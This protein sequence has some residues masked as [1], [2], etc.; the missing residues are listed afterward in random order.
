MNLV[1]HVEGRDTSRHHWCGRP[2]SNCCFDPLSLWPSTV[3]VYGIPYAVVSLIWMLLFTDCKTLS[4]AE[5]FWRLLLVGLTGSHWNLSHHWWRGCDWTPPLLHC[6][7]W[8][9]QQGYI[10]TTTFYLCKCSYHWYYLPFHL[11]TECGSTK[12]FR[13]HFIVYQ[14]F[15]LKNNF[16]GF[17][18]EK[19][20]VYRTGTLRMYGTV[21][22][23]VSVPHLERHQV[24]TVNMVQYWNLSFGCHYFPF[25]YKH[26]SSFSVLQNLPA[27]LSPS[28][29]VFLSNWIL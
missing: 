10:S 2:S 7:P 19:L 22:V 16:D 1:L 27:I 18:S 24:V 14:N 17:G 4:I 6:G 11:R 23:C 26:V 28:H 9:L 20:P 21:F 5:I 29:L 3:V 13:K 15:Y 25:L 8:Q 12:T